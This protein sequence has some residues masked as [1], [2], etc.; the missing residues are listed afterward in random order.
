MKKKG[1]FALCL[2]GQRAGILVKPSIAIP[3]LRCQEFIVVNFLYSQCFFSN[4]CFFIF[5]IMEI[6]D[7]EEYLA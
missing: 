1:G 7:F 5:L 3:S 2:H 6:M 4:E